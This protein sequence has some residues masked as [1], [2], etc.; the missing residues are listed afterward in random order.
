MKYSLK[1]LNSFGVESY[2]SNLFLINSIKDFYT[3]DYNIRQQEKII[4]GGGTNIL[5]K[6]KFISKPIFKIQIQGIEICYE[7]NDEVLISVGA[8]VNWD[9]F[10]WWCVNKNFGGIENLVLIPG[11]VGSAPIQNIGAY[12]KEVNDVIH[13]CEGIFIKNLEKKTFKNPDC[14]FGYRSSIFKK[15]LKNEF[16]ITK[17]NFI[18]KKNN[19]KIISNYSSVL[20]ALKKRQISQPSIKDI[21]QIVKE[22]RE[23]KLPDYNELGNAGS[24]FK[25][26]VIDNKK[27]ERLCSRFDDIPY[28]EV[29]HNLIKVPA[30][31]LI[32][33]CGF[34]KTKFNNVGVHKNQSLVI[35]NLGNAKG[36]DIFSFSQRIKESVYKKFDILLE[37][38]VT[39]V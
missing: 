26:P 14:N 33:M 10:V 3:I 8:G 37:E 21:A 11:N 27:F 5:L 16:A 31:W 4:L 32:E 25:N 9:E 36:I 30:A 28:Y 17:V 34:K 39:V 22:I 6:S 15:E 2:S 38:E 18:L 19:H 29:N 20:S 24:F 1:E 12:G 7:K 35:I 23:R 13:S